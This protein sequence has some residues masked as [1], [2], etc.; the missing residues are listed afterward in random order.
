MSALAQRGYAIFKST[1]SPE[2]PN[3]A[4]L[5]ARLRTLR[6]QEAARARYQKTLASLEYLRRKKDPRFQRYRAVVN[7][8][9][10]SYETEMAR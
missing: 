8:A 5:D 1:I 7:E 4:E 2:I 9:R 6:R 10:R 3:Y